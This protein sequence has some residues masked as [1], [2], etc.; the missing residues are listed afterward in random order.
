MRAQATAGAA[1]L[2]NAAA[3]YKASGIASVQTTAA[4]ATETDPD[5]PAA[6]IAQG[7]ADMQAFQNMKE[8]K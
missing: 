3:D 2:E 7:K 5:S 1:H 8:G 4:K 6:M